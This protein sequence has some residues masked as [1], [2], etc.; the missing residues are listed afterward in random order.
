MSAF[1]DNFSEGT[2][3][4]L[5]LKPLLALALLASLVSCSK[6][7][8]EVAIGRNVAQ[9]TF[10]SP[11]AA[12]AA[13][14]EAAK[15]GDRNALTAIFGPEG[16]DFVFSDDAVKDKNAMQHFVNAYGQMNRW[17][18]RESG[19]EILYIGAD[20]FTFPIPLSQ[21]TPGVW[22]F[23]TAA[24]KDEVLARRIGDGE[25]TAIG[26]LTEIANAQQEYFSQ[27]H[28]FALKFV[29]DENQHDGL[30][31]P[32]AE[33]Q[34][35]S[36]LGRLA[37]EAKAV[38]YSQSDKPQPFNG[39]YYRILTRQGDAAKG[40]AKDYVTGGKLTGGFAVVAWPAKYKDS[41]IM[42]F[43]VGKEGIIYQK[44]LGENTGEAAAAITA[45]NPGDGWTVVL[46]PDAVDSRRARN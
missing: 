18:A 39:Y 43:I 33:S 1:A 20:N 25:L 44:D 3:F 38:G 14:F 45:Y 17:S 7:E 11:A 8:S 6:R 19:D 24:G 46:A 26:L 9:K 16:K 37:E 28:Q 35:A 40:G 5:I 32:S 29:S 23:N 31:W 2:F 21:K 36:P 13:L 15:T 30:Y 42:T 12:G 10:A 27:T 4:R 34:R 41:G 22:A